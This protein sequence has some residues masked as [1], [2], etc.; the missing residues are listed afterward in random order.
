MAFG[1]VLSRCGT[2]SIDVAQKVEGVDFYR[3]TYP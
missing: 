2:L 1:F 3:P